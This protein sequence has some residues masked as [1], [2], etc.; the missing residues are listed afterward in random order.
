MR[1]YILCVEAPSFISFYSFAA[2]VRAVGGSLIGE[3]GFLLVKA[4]GFGCLGVRREAPFN[5]MIF[6][7]VLFFAIKWLIMAFLLFLAIRVFSRRVCKSP[8]LVWEARRDSIIACISYA[9]LYMRKTSF[10]RFVRLAVKAA[11][12][13]FLVLL[14]LRSGM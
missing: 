3:W 13:D 8:T 6:R 7:R 2:L 1:R 5:W 11:L 12:N 9:V 4:L 14:A 10:M